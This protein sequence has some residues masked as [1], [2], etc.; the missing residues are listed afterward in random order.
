MGWWRE[1]PGG[2]GNRWGGEVQPCFPLSLPRAINPTTIFP[3]PLNLGGGKIVREM[4]R[5]IF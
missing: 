1:P 3:E 2:E 5:K 4:F